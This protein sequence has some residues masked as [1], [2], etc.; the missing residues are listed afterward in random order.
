MQKYYE[1]NP[2]TEDVEPVPAMLICPGRK[3]CDN[4]ECVHA[5]PHLETAEC[6]TKTS[7]CLWWTG[8][9]IEADLSCP[10]SKEAICNK[11]DNMTCSRIE[12]PVLQELINV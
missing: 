1:M 10:F 9:C 11:P 8:K 5:S 12:C 3:Q 2:F 6:A 4:A 7:A